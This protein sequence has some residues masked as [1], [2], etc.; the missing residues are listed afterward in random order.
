M[1]TLIEQIVQFAPGVAIMAYF[2]YRA[3]AMLEKLVNRCLET[4]PCGDDDTNQRGQ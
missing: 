2:A 1:D 3:L 4:D